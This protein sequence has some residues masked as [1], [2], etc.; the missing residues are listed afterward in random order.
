MFISKRA[1]GSVHAA[2]CRQFNECRRGPMK[3]LY[4]VVLLLVMTASRFA[5][6]DDGTA[7]CP[8]HLPVSIMNVL[9]KSYLGWNVASMKMLNQ[10]DQKRFR[11]YVNVNCYGLISG[12]FTSEG[13]SYAIYLLKKKG[14]NYVN[15][16]VVFQ[17]TKVKVNQYVLI[18]SSNAASAVILRK[19]PRRTRVKD[20]ETGRHFL[21]QRDIVDLLDPDKGEVQ[22]I[23]KDGKFITLI[24]SE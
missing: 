21:A 3:N 6:A 2:I 16:L 22:F 12:N 9:S 11:P 15:E 18:P 5:V 17:D 20:A 4:L 7:P 24:S 8:N 14:D 19:V 10:Q 23:W 1:I 13:T